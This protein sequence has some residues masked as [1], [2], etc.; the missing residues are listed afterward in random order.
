AVAQVVGDADQR[1]GEGAEGVGKGGA[2]GDRRNRDPDR[3]RS[4]DGRAD[5]EADRDPAVIDDLVVDQRA[6]DGEEHA[7]LGEE[8]SAARGLRMAQAP[9]PEDEEDRRGEVEKL[10]HV[11]LHGYLP[12][13]N[14][15]RIRSV[16]R[17]PPTTLMVEATTARKPSRVLT[18]S[19]P[20]PATT[21]DPTSEMPEMALVADM[22]GVCSSGETREITW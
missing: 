4:S 14:I 13:R 19:Y 5:D 21:R 7:D 9:E 20:A 1:G 16:M 12:A 17:N 8:H 11:P 18:L 15:F 2:L 22:S 3:H 6:D 10:Q